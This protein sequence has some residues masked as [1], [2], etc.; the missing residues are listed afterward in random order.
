LQIRISFSRPEDLPM[1]NDHHHLKLAMIETQ[2][3]PE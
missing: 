3:E 2:P 1:E